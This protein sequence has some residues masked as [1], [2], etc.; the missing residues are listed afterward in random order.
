MKQRFL[1]DNFGG[2]GT[3]AGCVRRLA[4]ATEAIS[5]VRH[6][7]RWK[8]PRQHG[9]CKFRDEW[10]CQERYK[11]W[12]AKDRS[13]DTMA[14][15]TLCMKQISV[16]NAGKYGLDSHAKSALHRQNEACRNKSPSMLR[17]AS[18]MSLTDSPVPGPST[19]HVFSNTNNGK[20]EFHFHPVRHGTG[21]LVQSCL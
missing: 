19:G 9:N 16:A 20:G 12:V 21:R 18:S 15:C 13:D 10:L 11:H 2:C 8:M 17:L 1:F 3:E 7:L 5:S 14:R 4:S 6:F